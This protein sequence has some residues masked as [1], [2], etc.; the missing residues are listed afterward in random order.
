MSKNN[1]AL[2]YAESLRPMLSDLRWAAH[3][4]NVCGA[5]PGSVMV[6]K[7]DGWE[8][9]C[10]VEDHQV[11][12]R[13]KVFVKA[14]QP[15][16]SIPEHEKD[17]VIAVVFD[18]M[19]DKGTPATDITVISPYCVMVVQDFVPVLLQKTPT[20]RGHIKVDDSVLSEAGRIV[21]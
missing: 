9:G 7:R 8:F 14:E 6:A 16:C 4:P 11:F 10:K 2:K 13:R 18:E 3:N 17:P 12:F 19:L 15:M 5:V 1:K 21:H 20:A